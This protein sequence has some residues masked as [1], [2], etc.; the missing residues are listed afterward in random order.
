MADLRARQIAEF[1]EPY[2]VKPGSRLDE[3][4]GRGFGAERVDAPVHVA[5]D[6]AVVL[7][8]GG[9]VLVEVLALHVGD[10][11]RYLP[12]FKVVD[13]AADVSTAPQGALVP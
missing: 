10:E 6:V 11:E 3:H 12:V 8:V 1:I 7:H 5:H 13:H 4:D 9:P 2:R